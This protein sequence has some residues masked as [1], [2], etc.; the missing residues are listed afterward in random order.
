MNK[1]NYELYFNSIIYNIELK[2][3]KFFK[4]YLNRQLKTYTEVRHYQYLSH[5]IADLEEKLN[6]AL[7]LSENAEFLN[8]WYKFKKSFK[9]EKL[10]KFRFYLI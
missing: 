2:K 6:S 7:S 10:D 5:Q 3:E 1:I 4:I 9:N 8:D